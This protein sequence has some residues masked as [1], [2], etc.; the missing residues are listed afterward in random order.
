M[1]AQVT[2]KFYEKLVNQVIMWHSDNCCNPGKCNKFSR[3][4]LKGRHWTLWSSF[5]IC[6]TNAIKNVKQKCS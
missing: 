2:I 6:S 3:Q 4:K 5:N 1:Y